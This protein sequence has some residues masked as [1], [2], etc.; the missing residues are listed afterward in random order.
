VKKVEPAFAPVLHP[1]FRGAQQGT[2]IPL[3]LPEMGKRKWIACVTVSVF[4]F[5][6]SLR[7]MDSIDM[8]DGMMD[9]LRAS[10]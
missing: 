4:E 2:S 10:I 3:E 9:D 5:Q 1:V 6:G 7:S 8:S